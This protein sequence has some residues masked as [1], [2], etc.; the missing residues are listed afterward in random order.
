MIAAASFFLFALLIHQESAQLLDSNCVKALPEEN[1][2]VPWLAFIMTPSKN[3]SGA[4]INKQF[5]LTAARCVVGEK[6]SSVRLNSEV[7][8]VQNTYLPTN[9]RFTMDIALLKLKEPVIYKRHIRPICIL[10][11]DLVINTGMTLKD[12]RWGLTG[13]PA[14]K[15]ITNFENAKCLSSF[16]KRLNEFQICAGY[17]NND[18]CV[19]VGSP[20]CIEAYRPNV[21]IYTL[22]GI[23][24]YGALGTC[25]YSNILRYIGW[26]VGVVLEV[27]V[28]VHS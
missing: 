28:C 10:L 6:D 11:S 23:Q 22:T 24:S 15:I 2:R 5:V 18:N 27:D 16:G 21:T 9:D 3:C 7:Y 12:T 26:I 13:S 4:L 19:E 14:T 25:V 20:L 17:S 1:E 8:P